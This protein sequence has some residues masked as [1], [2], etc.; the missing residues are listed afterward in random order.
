MLR[1]GWY[2]AVPHHLCAPMRGRGG[3][4]MGVS[5]RD[6]RKSGLGGMHLEGLGCFLYGG[7]G[8]VFPPLGKLQPRD[9]R[10]VLTRRK[11]AHNPLK[12]CPTSKVVVQPDADLTLTHNQC[13]CKRGREREPSDA[14][15]NV[16]VTEDP[17]DMQAGLQAYKSASC[18][19]CTW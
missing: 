5:G 12:L 8:S 2:R 16:V 3:Q 17:A 11:Y 9:S 19:S 4:W 18:P 10:K 13:C 6:K 14:V 1:R 7:D 15:A